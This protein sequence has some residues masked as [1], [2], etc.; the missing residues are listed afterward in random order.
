[1]ADYGLVTTPQLHYMVY[2]RNTNGQYGKATTDGYYQKLS[3]AF[4]ELTKQVK[5][6]MWLEFI[7]VNEITAIEQF[8]I[9]IA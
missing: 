5:I 3:T 8:I 1:M 7:Q 9:V 2:C 4:V 6:W